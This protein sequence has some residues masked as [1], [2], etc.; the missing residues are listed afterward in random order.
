MRLSVM[1][2]SFKSLQYSRHI[3]NAFLCIAASI[4]IIVSLLFFLR[5]TVFDQRTYLDLQHPWMAYL[6][7]LAIDPQLSLLIIQGFM[8]IMSVLIAKALLEKQ[9][10]IFFITL[11]CTP[12]FYTVSL[13]QLSLTFSVL[14]FLAIMYCMKK[15][16]KWHVVGITLQIILV[17]VHVLFALLALIVILFSVYMKQTRIRTGILY[18]F[19]LAVGTLAEIYAY[20]PIHLLLFADIG[21]TMLSVSLIA[22]A[23]FG[24]LMTKKKEKPIILA[25]TAAL[26]VLF[27]DY[28]VG[29]I[30]VGFVAAYFAAKML[31]ELIKQHWHF[32][33][34]KAIA[35]VLIFCSLGLPT[36]SM[37]FDKFEQEILPDEI[38]NRLGETN[39]L[40][41]YQFGG[42]L[43]YH[44]AQ[45]LLTPNFRTQDTA[46]R[47]TD[48]TTVFFSRNIQ[49]TTELLEKY[50]ITHILITP[51]MKTTLWENKNQGLLFLLATQENMFRE[52]YTSEGFTIWEYVS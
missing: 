25:G 3:Q 20:E 19:P 52:V 12:A 13:G 34:L 43:A 26:L 6:S 5:G 2:K 11:A 38:L 9:Y 15:G 7:V 46:E 27:F 44:G 16:K 42:V 8:V 49:R 48:L 4:P 36:A 22:L 21:G 30:V 23:C 10:G 47:Y 41:D 18:T 28:E 17:I 32:S 51:S 14:L 40:T 50:E 37:I 39:V 33:D 31:T 35:L 29:G 1:L 45:P 24:L